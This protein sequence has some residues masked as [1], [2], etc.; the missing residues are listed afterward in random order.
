MAAMLFALA[1]CQHDTPIEDKTDLTSIAYNPATYNLSYPSNFPQLEN[2]SD[3][4]L[5]VEGVQLGRRLF[6][7][8]ILSA[9]STMSC[10]SCHKLADA[11]TDGGKVSVGIDGIAGKRSAMSLLNVGFFYNGLQWDGVANGLE[12]QSVMPVENPVELHEQWGNVVKKLK[13][14]S[15]YPTRFR[16]AFG[17]SKTDEITPDLAQ[18]AIAQFERIMV[19]GGG[20]KYDRVLRGEAFFTDEELEGYDMFFDISAHIPDAE[21]GHCHNGPLM[22]T[23]DYFNNGIEAA[24]TLFDFPDKGRGLVTSREQDNGKFRAPS[25]RNIALTAPYMH[26][27]RFNTLEEVLD[28]YNSGGHYSPNKNPLIYPLRLTDQQKS[29]VIAFLHTLTDTT[30]LQ[31]PDLQNPF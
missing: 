21:C 1:A 14:H 20:A 31:N 7:D 26:D 4:P 29:D 18:K 9:D 23:N 6:Y 15:D 30:Y 28:H 24:S 17:I 16:K 19:S 10:S 5:T 8:P 2:P 27:G 11:F 22:T 13:R 25:L 3:N 12:A